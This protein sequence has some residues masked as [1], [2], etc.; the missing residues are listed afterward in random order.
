MFHFAGDLFPLHACYFQKLPWHNSAGWVDGL[1]DTC[2]AILLSQGCLL[3]D[4]V[5]AKADH[6]CVHGV[7]GNKGPALPEI[8]CLFRQVTSLQ[9]LMYYSVIDIQ[10]QTCW[11]CTA[12]VYV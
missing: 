11:V 8:W 6:I 2:S 5:R 1:W 3:T 4:C 12:P 10:A 9:G 7:D